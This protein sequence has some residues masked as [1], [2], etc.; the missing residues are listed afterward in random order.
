MDLKQQIC[1]AR[2]KYSKIDRNDKIDKNDKNDT[3]AAIEFLLNNLID[4]SCESYF[5]VSKL[6]PGYKQEGDGMVMETFITVDM[7][8]HLRNGDS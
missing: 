1:K 2:Q 3:S 6:C 5:M 7:S 4:I 8:R